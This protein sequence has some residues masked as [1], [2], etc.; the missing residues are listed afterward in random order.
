MGGRVLIASAVSLASH[1]VDASQQM[2]A[3][4]G[5]SS[6]HGDGD[7]PVRTEAR[8]QYLTISGKKERHNCHKGKPGYPR[9]W[10]WLFIPKDKMDEQ[11][12]CI[13]L[14]T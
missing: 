8:G 6:I 5:F 4:A 1:T 7:F 2:M 13:L 14:G 10:G 3:T 9:C 12:I 11:P